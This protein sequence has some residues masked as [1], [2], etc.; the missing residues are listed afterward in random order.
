LL[1]SSE[2]R[3]F[4]IAARIRVLIVPTGAFSSSPISR[5]V[6]PAKAAR[7]NARRCGSGSSASAPRTRSRSS[8]GA[9]SSSA[10]PACWSLPA[11]DLGVQWLRPSHAH[12]VDRRVAGDRQQPGGDAAAPRV[13]GARVAPRPHERLLRHVLGGAGIA[14]DR[15]HEPVHARLVAADES[16]GRVR[17]PG[18]KA[19]Q[20]RLV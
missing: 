3:N 5:A 14:H 16:R 13:I 4:S 8:G 19:R 11:T 10:P 20:Q 7:N 2:S 17:L 15:D 6:R 18:R 1:V 12:R 9:R